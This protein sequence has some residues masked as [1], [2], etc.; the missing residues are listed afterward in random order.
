M[1]DCFLFHD[2]FELLEIR[3]NALAPYVSQFVLCE[4]PV[5]HSGN[6]KP[7]YFAENSYKFRDFNIIHLIANG[8]EQH[9]HYSWYLEW[10]QREFL[11]NGLNNVGDE[12]I[13]LVSD[14]DEIPDITSKN[15]NEGVFVG[16]LYYYYFNCFSGKKDWYGTVAIRK[17]NIDNMNDARGKRFHQPVIGE[18]WHFSTLGNA[19][20]IQHKIESFAHQE[21]N[22]DR[23]KNRVSFNRENLFDPF[24][25]SMKRLTIEEPSG[26][27]WLLNNRDKYEYLWYRKGQ[28]E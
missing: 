10:Y 22:N 19:Q 14:I 2:E 20:K 24:S 21:F 5:T 11:L 16:K 8:Y 13:V 3:L 25:R 15:I 18:G 9:L 12:E 1:I 28:N 26:P 4:M 7:L 27:K 17:K 6:S 23:F